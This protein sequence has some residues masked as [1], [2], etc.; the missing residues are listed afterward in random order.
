MAAPLTPKLELIV[1]APVTPRLS[2]NV[3]APV[4]SKVEAM[5]AAPET[6]LVPSTSKVALALA[7]F[8][9]IPSF[10]STAVMNVCVVSL[11]R[12]SNLP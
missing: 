12:I 5:V 9:P 3:V 4:T 11:L 2:P 1:A 8:L 10:P 6:A 7:L